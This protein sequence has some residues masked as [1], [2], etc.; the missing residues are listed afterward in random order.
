M[1]RFLNHHLSSFMS[2]L[3]GRMLPSLVYCRAIS[4]WVFDRP[5]RP[6][7][8]DCVNPSLP[9]RDADC[10]GDSFLDAK[11]RAISV[12]NLRIRSF[13]FFTMIRS[14]KMRICA[15]RSRMSFVGGIFLSG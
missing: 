5:I 11:I 6:N 9:L 1:V 4:A 8:S 13:G 3:L 14:F 12:F 7:I 2:P 15:P 10:A